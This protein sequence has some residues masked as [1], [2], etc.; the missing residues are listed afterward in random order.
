MWRCVPAF[1]LWLACSTGLAAPPQVTSE[2]P[3]CIELESVAQEIS[4][5]AT[6][7]DLEQTTHTVVKSGRWSDADTWHEGQSPI[8]HARVRVPRGTTLTIDTQLAPA[9]DWIAVEGELN[10]ATDADTRLRVCTI[11]VKRGGA[12]KIASAAAPLAAEH[13]AEIVFLP[14]S[15]AKIPDRFDI[16]GGLISLGTAEV[17]GAFK[18]P[19]ALPVATLKSGQRTISFGESLV[20]WQAG[21]ELLFPAACSDEQDERITIQSISAD[22]KS[23][24]L[25]TPLKSAHRA[26]ELIDRTIPIGNLTRNVM[27]RSE[28]TEQLADRGHIIFMSHVGNEIHHARFAGLGRTSTKVAHT[29]PEIRDDGTIDNGD[30]PIGRYAV[31][32]H[33]RQAASLKLPPQ[34]FVGNVIVDSP[35]HGLVNHGSY[36]IAEGNVTYAVHGSHFFAENG[37]EIGAF[38]RNLAVYSGGSEDTIRSR[39]AVYDFG[40]GGHGFWTQSPAVTIEQNY[41]FHHAGAAFSIFA[42]PVYEF[43][44]VVFFRRENLPEHLREHGDSQLLSNGGVP[45]EF[46]HN[47]GAHAGIGL[48]LWNTNTYNESE[49]SSLVEHCTFW[50]TRDHG[51][52]MPY[53]LDTAIRDTKL[54]HSAKGDVAA[55]GL[56]INQSTNGLTLDRVLIAGYHIGVWCPTQG[57]TRITHCRLDNQHSLHLPTALAAG[58]VTTIENNTFGDVLARP[59]KD[60]V[61]YDLQPLDYSYRGDISVVFEY[62]DLQVRDA[63]FVNQALYF[64]EQHP[65]CVPFTTRMVPDLAGKTTQQLWNEYNLV[66]GGRLAPANASKHAHVRGWIGAAPQ[67]RSASDRTAKHAGASTID[68][69]LNRVSFVRDGQDAGWKLERRG[70]SAASS[71]TKLTYVD[72]QPPKFT[73]DPRIKLE[74][75][76][77]DVKH[78]IMLCG[79]MHDDI[80]DAKTV[81]NMIVEKKDLIIDDDGYVTV[82]HNFVDAVGNIDATEYRFKVT[83]DAVRRGPNLNYYAQ[84]H[85]G[86]ASDAATLHVDD[87]REQ[88]SVLKRHRLVWTWF[89]AGGFL[90]AVLGAAVWLRRWK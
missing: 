17:Y 62:D 80:G 59:I 90:S 84:K 43:G 75:H 44:K 29:L 58:R 69:N 48:E 12:L 65:Q 36:V 34:H 86:E 55:I 77:D 83:K 37:S 78:G 85:F 79:L 50:D 9:I 89:A 21:D 42:R 82:K 71:A 4:L 39:D 46:R 38:R 57:T 66:V 15:S 54:L 81:C 7:L 49:Q 26:P 76:P 40:H 20:G 28:R 53:T 25:A 87:V 32:F 10:F 51:I 61:D 11:L 45:F 52:F 73:L 63:R 68:G 88:A 23:V 19:F 70:D 1:V 18:T 60:R 64:P 27:F 31:H 5:A 3:L 30:N 2:E 67:S 72:K 56:M 14:R 6:L 13:S 16:T 8:A 74:I 22:R 24:T 33:L 41:A 35:K 47:V